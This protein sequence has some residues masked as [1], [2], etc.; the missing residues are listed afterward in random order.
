MWLGY[1]SQIS[2]EIN[3]SKLPL[4]IFLSLSN[5]SVYRIVCK[6]LLVF[7]FF[8]SLSFCSIMFCD[9]HRTMK[10]MQI[11]ITLRNDSFTLSID[12][13]YELISCLRRIPLTLGNIFLGVIFLARVLFFDDFAKIVIINFPVL[14]SLWNMSMGVLWI[15]VPL[16]LFFSAMSPMWTILTKIWPRSKNLIPTRIVL[17]VQK[18]GLDVLETVLGLQLVHHAGTCFS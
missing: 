13:P 2:F 4:L 12:F 18:G 8:W 10:P 16:V 14:W 15:I 7:V 17:L 6:R 11:R 9:A 1:I 3:D 5:N